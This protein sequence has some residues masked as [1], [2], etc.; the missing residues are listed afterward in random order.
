MKFLVLVTVYLVSC[1]GES[2]CS[3]LLVMVPSDTSVIT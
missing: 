2:V 3:F 1:F